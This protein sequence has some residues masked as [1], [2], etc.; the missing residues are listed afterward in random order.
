MSRLPDEA[1]DDLVR[2]G[3]LKAEPRS[4]GFGSLV[5]GVTTFRS[6][7][8]IWVSLVCASVSL[9]T[10]SFCLYFSSVTTSLLPKFVS[11]NF[12]QG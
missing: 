5:D 10:F 3:V 7:S 9:D 6:T 1:D 4:D 8:E 11:D 2:L 12:G